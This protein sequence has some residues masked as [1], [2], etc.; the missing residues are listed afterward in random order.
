MMMTN[1]P[2]IESCHRIASA[3][4]TREEIAALDDGSDSDTAR[5][6]R[7]ALR[8]G[9][10]SEMWSRSEDRVLLARR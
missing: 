7:A 4:V 3:A 8:Q 9:P 2:S 1:R 6:A 10:G 5:Q